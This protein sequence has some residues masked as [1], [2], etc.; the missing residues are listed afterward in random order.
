MNVSISLQLNQMKIYTL[1]SH[2]S[3]SKTFAN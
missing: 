1:R 3:E 2:I